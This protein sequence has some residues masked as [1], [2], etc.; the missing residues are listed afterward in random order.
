M[1][2]YLVQASYTTDAVSALIKR[3]QD[4]TE[5]VRKMMEEL[6]GR[7]IG[8]W[9]AF[10]EYDIVGIFEVPDNTAAIAGSMAISAS[11]ALKSVKTTP[12]LDFSNAV[13]AMKRAGGSGYTPV[14]SKS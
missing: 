11:G 3:P 8:I 12:L 5:V 4:R 6:G 7:L 1:P 2:T 9:L 13:E 14:T 10:G